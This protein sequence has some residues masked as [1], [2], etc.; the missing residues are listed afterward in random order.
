MSTA[1]QPVRECKQRDR[2]CA[3]AKHVGAGLHCNG[4]ERLET[5]TVSIGLQDDAESRRSDEPSQV[6]N[7]NEESSRATRESERDVE[8]SSPTTGSGPIQ[9]ENLR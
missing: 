5:M 6:L 2:I 3:N 1:P 8:P 7:V 4:S 9:S